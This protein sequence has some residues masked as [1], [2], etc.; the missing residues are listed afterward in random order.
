MVLVFYTQFQVDLRNM[1]LV[2]CTLS[3]QCYTAW[4]CLPYAKT[5]LPD[6]KQLYLCSIF[7]IRCQGETC[8]FNKSNQALNNPQRLDLTPNNGTLHHDGDVPILKELQRFDLYVQF[9]PCAILQL[10]SSAVKM[11]CI[12]RFCALNTLYRYPI[13]CEYAYML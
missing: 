4:H 11:G 1:V 12:R 13:L 5:A 3:R 6:H 7:R 2:C 8:P 10:L 9:K